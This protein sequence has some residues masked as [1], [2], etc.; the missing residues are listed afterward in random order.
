MLIAID[1]IITL[2]IELAI[3]SINASSGR[4]ATSVIAKSERGEH[5]RVS[6]P[7]KNVS[8]RNNTLHVFNT[9]YETRNNIPDEISELSVPGTHF[10]RQ[11]HT[12]HT[13]ASKLSKNQK[14]FKIGYIFL[15]TL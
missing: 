4:D 2:G 10:D 9:N 15:Y 13:T 3:R 14:E 5:R 11:P 1:S 7:F 8:E 6:A 12:H